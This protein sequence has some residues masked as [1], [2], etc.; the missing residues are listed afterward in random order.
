MINSFTLNQQMC[1]LV[2][3]CLFSSLYAQDQIKECTDL[4]RFFEQS[5][6]ELAQLEKVFIQKNCQEELVNE[7]CKKLVP[8]IREIQGA[9]TMLASRIETQKCEK[10]T[11]E[12]KQSQTPC[13]RMQALLDKTENQLNSIDQQMKAYGC[14][15]DPS[16]R[17]CQSLK[18]SLV[19][20]TQIKQAAIRQ[21]NTLKCDSLKSKTP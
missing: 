12:T 4:W 18:R 14:D 1:L 3:T 19:Q 10:V 9:L 17:T 15:E 13:S 7:D 8:A 5:H 11:Q 21:L 20:P 16:P 6:T 2:F